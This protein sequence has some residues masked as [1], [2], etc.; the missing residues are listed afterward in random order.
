[1][2][3]LSQQDI[4]Q[5]VRE[6]IVLGILLGE[7]DFAET[8]TLILRHQGGHKSREIGANQLYEWVESQEAREFLDGLIENSI[9]GALTK[10][11]EAEGE[12]DNEDDQ[13]DLNLLAEKE[14]EVMPDFSNMPENEE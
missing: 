12:N 1:M 2:P 8:I 14:N 7:N 11:K 5:Q 6:N 10:E 3:S 4:I 13:P 9:E